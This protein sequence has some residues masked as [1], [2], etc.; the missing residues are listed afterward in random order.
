M[1]GALN[2]LHELEEKFNREFKDWDQ[3]MA[4]T[5]KQK[6]VEKIEGDRIQSSEDEEIQHPVADQEQKK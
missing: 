5:A 3:L 1:I 2:T 6:A 4:Q